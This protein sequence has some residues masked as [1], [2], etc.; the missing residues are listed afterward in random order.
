MS[1]KTE[2]YNNVPIRTSTNDHAQRLS[3]NKLT[4]RNGEKMLKKIL[5]ILAL[6]LLI[7]AC[8]PQAAP[9]MAAADVQGTAV[10]AAWTMVASTQAAI[11]TNTPPPPTETASPT[12]LPTFTQQPLQQPLLVPTL[13]QLV[14]PTAAIVAPAAQSSD[15]NNCLKPLNV[16][17]A[18]PSK[19]TR[20]ENQNNSTLNISLNLTKPNT[21]G[22]CGSLSYTIDKGATRT[23]QI[24]SGYWWAYAWVLDPASEASGSFVVGSGTSSGAR[25]VIKKNTI[26]YFGQ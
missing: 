7:T 9:T 26:T 6:T 4:N 21:F 23:V 10:A 12:P 5:L 22:Q 25:L 24:P 13:P 11:P 19:N 8:A 1:L 14:M 18:G 2:I 17:E 16:A 15:P 20:L 3:R